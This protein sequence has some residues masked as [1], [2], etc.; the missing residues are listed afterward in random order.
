MDFETRPRF[1]DLNSQLNRLVLG[2]T[3][4]FFSKR[5]YGLVFTFKRRFENKPCEEKHEKKQMLTKCYLKYPI[6]KLKHAIPTMKHSNISFVH[7]LLAIYT[8]KVLNVLQFWQFD[9]YLIVFG[10]FEEWS[11]V[12]RMQFCKHCGCAA[13]RW[14]IFH[15]TATESRQGSKGHSKFELS[16]WV[17]LIDLRLAEKTALRQ[18]PASSTKLRLG[19]IFLLYMPGMTAEQLY[20][21]LFWGIC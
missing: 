2:S 5:N 4:L 19:S 12:L 11:I 18:I 14:S 15:L 7:N 13:F 17:M 10:Q 8:R 6:L 1:L 9:V 16:T 21:F 3:F 20:S